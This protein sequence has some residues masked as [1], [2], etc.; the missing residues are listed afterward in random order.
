MTQ[1]RFESSEDG[2]EEPTPVVIDCDPG[3]D[4]AIAILLALGNPNLDVRAIT[5][6]AG[7]RD[8]EQVTANALQIA[9]IAGRSDLTIAAG[10]SA[11]LRRAPVRAGAIHGE[12]G[13]GNYQ[14]Q[15]PIA[16][17]DSR[18][19]TEVLS[20]AIRSDPGHVVVIGIGPLTNLALALRADPELASQA[21]ELIFMG[22]AYTRG[23]ITPAA[24]FNMYGDPEAA[25]EVLAARWSKVTMVGLE[26]TDQA[27]ATEDVIDRIRAVGT[28]PANFVADLITPYAL[29]E[30]AAKGVAAPAIHDACAVAVAADPR[31]TVTR[32]A[33][34]NVETRGDYT[35]GMTVTDF[36]H[37]T[38]GPHVE[39]A[40]D[41]NTERFWTL[42]LDALDRASSR[43]HHPK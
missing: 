3:I 13:L 19:A 29:A 33:V 28:G 41:L 6:V 17:L 25:A 27:R 42:L 26:L 39:V 11:P 9:T 35:S 7:N 38:S 20:D 5:T 30:K 15:P 37:R 40:T 10:A 12:S 43:L 1:N 18:S 16:R 21:R 14:P 31:V 4:D 34:V 23:N 2:V 8:I 24:E 32:S 22:G 36:S